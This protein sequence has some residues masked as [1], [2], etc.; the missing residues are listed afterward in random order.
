MS[1]STT[2]LSGTGHEMS[3]FFPARMPITSVRSGRP[4][5]GAA[6]RSTCARPGMLPTGNSTFRWSRTAAGTAY[7]RCL[8]RCK[9]LFSSI[10]LIQQAIRKIPDG[11]IEVKVTGAPNGEFFCR[12]EQPRGELV[13][14]IKGN[15]TKFLVRSRIRTPTLSNIPS[16]IKMLQGCRA[17]RCP[18]DRVVDRSLY[19]AVRSGDLRWAFSR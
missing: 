18:G 2:I 7:S 17:C 3:G 14:Y 19:R 4:A 10:D 6:S 8:V 13:H 15:G 12:A 11:P 16:L 9:E 5:G 1:S